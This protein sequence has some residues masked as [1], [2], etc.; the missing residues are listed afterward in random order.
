MFDLK[1]FIVTNI[2]NGIKN[3]TF[4]K[5]YGNIMAV[6][7]LAKGMLTE[8]NII[9]IHTQI[10]EWESSLAAEEP[11]VEEPTVE[12]P[13]VEEPTVEEPVEDELVEEPPVEEP[14]TIIEPENAE[15]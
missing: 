3:G 1:A 4:T 11:A 9:D 8:E 10:T 12:E 14:E 7:Y 15:I 13:V 2:V 6:N 5:E